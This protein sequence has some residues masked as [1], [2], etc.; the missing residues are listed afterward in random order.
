MTIPSISNGTYH[1]NGVALDDFTSHCLEVI[2]DYLPPRSIVDLSLVNKKIANKLKNKLMSA[3]EAECVSNF[4]CKKNVEYAAIH[5]RGF[6]AITNL[7]AY[8]RLKPLMALAKRI[9]DLPSYGDSSEVT[10]KIQ[11]FKQILGAAEELDFEQKLEILSVLA[12]QLGSNVE[13][14][15]CFL[16]GLEKIPLKERVA[17]SCKVAEGSEKLLLSTRKQVF[18]MMLTDAESSSG[19]ARA[20]ILKQVGESGCMRAVALEGCDRILLASK[21]LSDHERATALSGFATAVRMVPDSSKEKAFHLLL[22]ASESLPVELHA[23]VLERIADELPLL[24]DSVD[25]PR[26]VAGLPRT[27]FCGWKFKQQAYE[28]ISAAMGKLPNP[29]RPTI[30]QK[31]F[32]QLDYFPRSALPAFFDSALIAARDNPNEEGAAIL[33]NCI[34]E[35][36]HLREPE[37]IRNVYEQ[38]LKACIALSD[39]KR[40]YVL[41]ISSFDDLSERDRMG[42][43]DLIFM[44]CE[45][46]SGHLRADTLSRYLYSL[47][48]YPQESRFEVFDRIWT[49]LEDEEREGILLS[50]VRGAVDLSEEFQGD[51]LDRIGKASQGSSDLYRDDIS[52]AYG[53]VWFR[54]PSASRVDGFDFVLN[55]F[56]N[57]PTDSSHLEYGQREY[58][59]S[60]LAINIHMLQDHSRSRAFERI[61]TASEGLPNHY[62]GSVL[63]HLAETVPR[64]STQ[65]L[66][67]VSERLWAAAKTIQGDLGRELMSRLEWNAKK[68]AP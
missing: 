49:V 51:A 65:S 40:A 15:K 46:M 38:T 18:N 9:S 67:E 37:K 54:L 48:C 25:M 2:S 23:A 21:D 30:L 33:R 52:R 10:T 29:L 55:G 1:L 3:R 41:E 56:R 4:K 22:T 24:S 12:G 61:L 64:L 59:L 42:V 50:F 6:N 16:E 60:S 53:S 20:K 5:E 11:G 31:L 13:I 35:I 47:R 45:K 19:G 7:P 68:I 32:E 43:F 63:I 26:N 27:E 28:L 14:C 8:L 39:E 58:C 17:I 34:R 62:R 36:S 57:L 66:A 44:N